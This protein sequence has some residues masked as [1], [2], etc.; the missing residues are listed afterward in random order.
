[1]QN[2]AKIYLANSRNPKIKSN[3]I[4]DK[5][6]LGNYHVLNEDPLSKYS[7]IISLGDR[8]KTYAANIESLKEENK[9][10]CEVEDQLY[11]VNPNTGE[12]KLSWDL[13]KENFEKG[14]KLIDEARFDETEGSKAV[15]V[16]CNQGQSRSAAF[17][18]AYIMNRFTIPF[19]QALIFVRNKRPSVDF[20]ALPNIFKLDHA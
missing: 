17:L 13:L 4:L 19:E 2:A 7:R 9:L 10:Q 16:Q 3:E 5:V 1:M 15:Y 14:F 18:I 8:W 12:R 6:F 20:T 11:T